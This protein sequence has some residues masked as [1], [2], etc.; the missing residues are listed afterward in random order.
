[1][2]LAMVHKKGLWEGIWERAR[3]QTYD[4]TIGCEDREETAC[5]EDEVEIKRKP[6]RQGIT[7]VLSSLS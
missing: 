4:E 7:P 5:L 3:G 1:M 2:V 6:S